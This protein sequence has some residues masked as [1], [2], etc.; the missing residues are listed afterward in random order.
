MSL[1]RL[2][3]KLRLIQKDT[4]K[5]IESFTEVDGST[6]PNIYNKAE[7]DLIDISKSINKLQNLAEKTTRTASKSSP[8]NVPD[9]R[10]GDVS[11]E[12][13]DD[14]ILES[15]DSE[16]DLLIPKKTTVEEPAKECKKESNKPKPPHAAKSHDISEGSTE[17]GD[18]GDSDDT[19]EY[20]D[21][22]LD[23]TT[24][25]FDEEFVL[26]SPVTKSTS[27]SKSTAGGEMPSTSTKVRIP[28]LA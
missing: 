23:Q 6:N 4:Q 18:D 26:D 22:N 3:A 14:S 12:L 1:N 7:K 16:D 20:V 5:L 17:G 21:Q 19:A 28:I 15:S 10:N 13:I 24:D 9:S 2:L 25:L 11:F 8:K 27:K